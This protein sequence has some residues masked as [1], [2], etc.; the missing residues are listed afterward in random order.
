MQAAL[1]RN[2]SARDV[3]QLGRGSRIRRP[4]E[5]SRESAEG[6]AA[7]VTARS[8]AL[9]GTRLQSFLARVEARSD[10][11]GARRSGFVRFVVAAGRRVSGLIIS[12]SGDSAR[13]GAASAGTASSF[14]LPSR[15]LK[16]PTFGRGLKT[17]LS[18][19][20]RWTGSF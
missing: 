9:Q 20:S 6:L 3:R 4:A 8:A 18:A 19:A 2:G 15:M 12:A 10:I 17:L 11:E 16:T 14:T 13:P 1:P 5:T 7:I